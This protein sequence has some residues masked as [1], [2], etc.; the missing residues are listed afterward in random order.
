[1]LGFLILLFILSIYISTITSIL[2]IYTRDYFLKI[3]TKEQ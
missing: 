2:Y 1:M 3:K